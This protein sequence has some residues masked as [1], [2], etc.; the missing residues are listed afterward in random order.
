[1]QSSPGVLVL[2]SRKITE[3]VEPTEA[4]ESAAD[5]TATV[6][7]TENTTGDKTENT[8]GDT[9]ATVTTRVEITRPNKTEPET[10]RYRLKGFMN[11][12]KK[13]S[14][15]APIVGT[16]PADSVVRVLEIVDD[17]L[18]LANDTYI[19]YEN[20]KWAEKV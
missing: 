17:W 11:V 3:A 19:L 4:V 2:H 10:T 20:G 14:L 5:N 8:A 12:R 16:R 9:T 6:D 18:H 1:M 7:A 15:H 13:P